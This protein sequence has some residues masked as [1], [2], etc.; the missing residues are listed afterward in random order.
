[1]LKLFLV[2]KKFHIIPFTWKH[3]EWLAIT[4]GIFI[5]FWKINLPFDP[6]INIVVR[7][8]MASTLYG[9][10]VYNRRISRD[11]NEL[12]DTIITRQFKR[13]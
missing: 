11:I 4:A 8:V 13:N 3:V 1:M 9:G 2:Y 7:S 6:I 5:I 12:I 10:L